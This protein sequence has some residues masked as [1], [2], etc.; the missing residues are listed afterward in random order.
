[1]VYFGLHEFA[2]MG[3]VLHMLRPADLFVDIGANIGSFTI[4]A[5]KVSGADVIAFEPDSNTVATLER[6]IA[7][8]EVGGRVEVHTSALGDREQELW[9]TSGM[10]TINHVADDDTPGAVRVHGTTLD[11]VLA[12]RAPLLIKID[13][14]G[15]EP[16]VIAG[17]QKTLASPDLK[18]VEVE[19]VTQD[20]ADMLTAHGF[21]QRHYDP[22][23]RRLSQAPVHAANNSLYVRDEAFVA[24]RIEKA[25]PVDVYGIAV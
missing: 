4:L 3:F 21:A 7:A 8:N 11:T 1:N 14:E 25:A 10:D 15:H 5:A 6:N 18:A 12:G 22:F 17:A 24:D 16:A 19:T 2:D 13:V 9:F 23:T 20:I